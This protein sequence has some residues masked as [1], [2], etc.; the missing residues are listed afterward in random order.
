MKFNE[1]LQEG[2]ITE[3][4]V[5]NSIK[6]KYP[7]AYIVD[8]Y[9]KEHDIVIPELD[10]TIEVKQD[11]KSNYTGNY[12]VEIFMF[13]KPSGLLSSTADY[14]VFSDGYKL[15]WTTREIIK[16]KILLEN[17][18]LITFTGKGDTEPKLAYLVPKEDI[19][20]TALR[21]IQLDDTI[22]RS[23]TE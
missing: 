3:N 1:S 15:I 12:V 19:E 11:K 17:Y 8:G 9:C 4:Y 16:D 6:K 22:S 5:L 10:Q 21:V 18:K 7:K 14:W 23:T 20:E 13:G 2:K